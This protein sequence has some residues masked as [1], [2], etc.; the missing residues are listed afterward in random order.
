[1]EGKIRESLVGFTWQMELT[2]CKHSPE[3]E[4]ISQ[5]PEESGLPRPEREAHLLGQKII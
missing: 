4:S 2:E 3:A 1:M 5:D